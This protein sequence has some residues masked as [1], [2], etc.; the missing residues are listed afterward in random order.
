MASRL[1]YLFRSK[2]GFYEYRRKVPTRLRP[3][4]PSTKTGKL[5][6]EWKKSLNTKDEATAHKR[7]LEEN[8]RFTVASATAEKLLSGIPIAPYEVVAAGKAIAIKDGVHP[9][10]APVLHA[11]ATPEETIN[12]KKQAAEWNEF[13]VHMHDQYID[14]LDRKYRDKDGKEVKWQPLDPQVAAYRI[15][16]GKEVVSLDPSWSDAVELYIKVNKAEKKREGVKEQKWEIST[17]NLLAKFASSN[18]GEH[19]KL[20]DLDRQSIRD[21]LIQTYPNVSTRNRYNNVLSAVINKWNEEHKSKVYNP[22]SGLSNKQLEQEG[23][24]KRRSFTPEEWHNYLAYVESL[25][26]IQL[27]L[28]GLL[29]LYT[30]CRTNEAAGLQVRDFRNSD[31]M[32]HVVFRT[33]ALRRMDKN[34]L[35]RAVPLMT[36]ILNAYRGYTHETRPE[37]PLFPKYGNTRGFENVSAKLR[38]VVNDLMGIKNPEVVPYSARH[39]LRDRSEAA[40][41]STSRAE[42]IMGHKSAGSS[43]VH[44]KYG[45]KTPPFVLYDDMLKIFQVTDWGYYED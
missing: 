26:D 27:K 4:F 38:H 41:I 44:Q 33:N 3:F 29:M 11:N 6:S 16:T 39:T 20:E 42:Y 25:D 35:E 32:P 24:I 13:I 7:W 22:F 10:Q 28:I 9:Q 14:D 31:N 8:K 34:G 21:W 40:N 15:M 12:F 36:P 2:T 37:A 30:G 23:A 18:G 5:M 1:S 17:R 43:R 19:L 45:T